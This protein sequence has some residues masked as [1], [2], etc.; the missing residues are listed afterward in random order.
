MNTSLLRILPVTGFALIVAVAQAAAPADQPAADAPKAAADQPAATAVDQ[1]AADP[2]AKSSSTKADT[3]I[4]VTR[5]VEKIDINTADAETLQRL[6]GITEEIA[7]AI[8]KARPFKTSSDLARVEGVG[9]TR[10]RILKSQ[11]VASET[12]EK[13]TPTGRPDANEPPQAAPEREKGAD[14][15][16]AP[17]ADAADKN[18][19]PED[20]NAPGLDAGNAPAADKNA[21][22]KPENK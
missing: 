10:A 1:P 13:L 14:D 7:Q 8:I 9:E 16:K 17:G 5:P 22:D 2:A 11:I 4:S 6:P 21:A 12:E 3:S 18:K 19:N 20:Q 15:Q